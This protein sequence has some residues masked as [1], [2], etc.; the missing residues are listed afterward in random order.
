MIVSG[1]CANKN[2]HPILNKLINIKRRYFMIFILSYSA[3]LYLRGLIIERG[4]VLIAAQVVYVVFFH[5]F[6]GS[7]QH[8]DGLFQR[9]DKAV[10][11]LFRVIQGNRGTHRTRHLQMIDQWFGTMM[12]CAHCHTLTI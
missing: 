5:P 4:R 6:L 1:S 10:N 11:I 3:P 2:P 7:F 9:S 12:S 8:H